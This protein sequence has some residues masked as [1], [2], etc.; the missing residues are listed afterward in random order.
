MI[1]IE[2]ELPRLLGSDSN[3]LEPI[4]PVV[5]IVPTDRLL[6]F[7]TQVL[8]IEQTLPLKVTFPSGLPGGDRARS[9]RRPRTP[10]REMLRQV[11]QVNRSAG[12]RGRER[13]GGV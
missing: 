6:G 13:R 2:V 10:F 3:S 7:P 11:R 9:L 12:G 8:L 4:L 5:E 1:S